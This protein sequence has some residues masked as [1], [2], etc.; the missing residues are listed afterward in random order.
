MHI[1]HGLKYWTYENWKMKNV[2]CMKTVEH[3]SDGSKYKNRIDIHCASK[4]DP[5]ILAVGLTW[6]NIV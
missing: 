6:A 3:D 5:N 2:L 4:K 1:A